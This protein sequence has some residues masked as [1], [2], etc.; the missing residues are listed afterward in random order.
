[1]RSRPAVLLMAVVL[2]G[3]GCHEKRTKAEPAEAES[4]TPRDARDVPRETCSLE[5]T[6]WIEEQLASTCVPPPIGVDV[7]ALAAAPWNPEPNATTGVGVLV[8]EDGTVEGLDEALA[9]VEPTWVLAA[10]AGAPGEAVA[11]VLDALAEVQAKRGA[12][13]LRTEG[14]PNRAVPRDPGLLSKIEGDIAS[15][16]PAERA[17]HVAR[18]LQTRMSGCEAAMETFGAFATM[19]PERR[20][21]AMPRLTREAIVACECPAWTDEVVTMLRIM[22]ES[23]RTTAVV[24]RLAPDAPRRPSADETWGA[25][26]ATLEPGELSI[27][28]EPVPAAEPT[29]SPVGLGALGGTTTSPG[30]LPRVRMERLDTSGSLAQEI[31][32]RIVRQRVGQVRLCLE[33]ALRI[34]PSVQGR[35]VLDMTLEA[36]GI[37]SKAAIR[38]S[39]LK[40]DQVGPCVARVLRATRFPRADGK[41]EVALDYGFSPD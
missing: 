18:E 14:G 34:D 13:L 36:D 17:A 24:V 6:A 35:L 40:D 9:R 38:S 21:E 32:R 12:I 1:M 20:C 5:A 8:R 29:A 25:F 37:V 16:Q 41:T 7:E 10:D 11:S 31:V 30:P 15:L 19:S 33:Q 3:S 2:G 26:V 23:P 22:T 4:S 27:R 28:V 39:T